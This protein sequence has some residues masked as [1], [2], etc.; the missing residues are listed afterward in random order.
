MQFFL[1]FTVTTLAVTPPLIPECIV[2]G[3]ILFFKQ[4]V[5]NCNA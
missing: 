4:K 2:K 5:F 1:K 3:G